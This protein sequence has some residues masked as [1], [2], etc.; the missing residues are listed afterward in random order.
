VRIFCRIGLILFVLVAASSTSAHEEDTL[1]PHNA[2]PG[3][4]LEITKL[5][6]TSSS[7]GPRYSVHAV[8]F[9]P[10]V[11]LDVWAQDFGHLFHL[12]ASGFVVNE[13]GNL[14]S[15]KTSRPGRQYQSNPITFGPGPYPRGAAWQVALVSVDRALA[16]KAFAAVIPYPIIGR[17]G[18]CKVQ[19]ELVSYGGDHFVATGAGFTPGDEVTT[20]SRYLGHVMEKRQRISSEGLLL[21]DVL[22]YE[23]I[24]ADRSARYTVKGRSCEVAVKYNWGK[25]ALNR[26]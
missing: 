16:L 11:V 8:G 10:G 23:A 15:K 25:P 18:P 4:Q 24:G 17:D 6:H 13:A 3:L 5:P 2:T 22:S 14:I 7:A 1:D 9:P 20:E 12:V 26:R 19:L 21:P